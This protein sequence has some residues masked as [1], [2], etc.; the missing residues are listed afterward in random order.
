MDGSTNWEI[1]WILKLFHMIS[2]HRSPVS[3]EV[4]QNIIF[5]IVHSISLQ[6]HPETKGRHNEGQL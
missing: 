6:H 4:L 2:R 3:E 1:F 5:K